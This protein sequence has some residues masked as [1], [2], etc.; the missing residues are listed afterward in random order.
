MHGN[1]LNLE[2][3]SEIVK[4][5]RE[6]HSERNRSDDCE[7]AI[8]NIKIDKLTAKYLVEIKKSDAD[9]EATKWQIYYYLS[10]LKKKGL[11]RTGKVEYIE[12]NR[13]NHIIYY[14]LTD[15]IEEELSKIEKDIEDLLASLEIP[16]AIRKKHCA[17]CAYFEY[18]YI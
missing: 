1:R 3:N 14:T 5:G 11:L 7:I 10:I 15:E 4:I 13:K 8:E 18:C 16:E 17:K 9:E 6:L 2:D 12:K